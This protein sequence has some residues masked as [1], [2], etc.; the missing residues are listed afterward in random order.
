MNFN[1]K[2]VVITGGSSGIGAAMAEQFHSR[3]A[4]III[5]DINDE[6]GKK[7]ATSLD[8][9]YIHCDVCQEPD[10]VQ[11]IEQVESQWGEIDCFVSNAGLGR[12]EGETAASAPND[13]WK[14]QMDI[15]LMSHVYAARALLPKMIE[16]GSGYLVQVAS[17]AGLLCQIMDSAYTASKHAAVGFAKSLALT[18]GD[19]GIGVSLVCPMYVDTPLV[20]IDPNDSIDDY[21]GVISAE[22]AATIIADGIEANDFLI[23]T[24]LE[25]LQHVQYMNTDPNAWVAGMHQYKRSLINT[26]GAGLN[27]AE[28]LKKR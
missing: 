26:A 8:G 19:Q 22:Q 12:G 5:A 14:L 13:I 6:L 21:N 28:S 25:T 3:G 9:L 11:L 10:I 23:S 4:R 24:H 1:N 2:I 27:I 20:G 17:A 7:T 18:H 16:R 15:H